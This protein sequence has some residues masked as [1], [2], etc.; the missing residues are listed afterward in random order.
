MGVRQCPPGGA[1]GVREQ[2]LTLIDGAVT[3]RGQLPSRTVTSVVRQSW[4]RVATYT[5]SEMFLN[6][7]GREQVKDSA[8]QP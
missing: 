8:E 3:I 4:R 5:S 1:V 2:R 7:D 6:A